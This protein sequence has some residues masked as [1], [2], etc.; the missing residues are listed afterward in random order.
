M[1]ETYCEIEVVGYFVDVFGVCVP[2]VVFT[3]ESRKEAWACLNN[4]RESD[5]ANTYMLRYA[6]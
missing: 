5:S 2:E 6:G 4:Y 3:A 1:S